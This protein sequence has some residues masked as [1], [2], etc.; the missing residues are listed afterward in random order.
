MW[1]PSDQQSKKTNFDK[2]YEKEIHSQNLHKLNI[3]L[4]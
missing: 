2:Y 4:L 1:I 3:V